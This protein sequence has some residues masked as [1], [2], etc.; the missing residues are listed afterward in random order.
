MISRYEYVKIKGVQIPKHRYVWEQANG[1]IPDGYDVHHIDGNGHNND[2]SNLQLIKHGE[3][4][5]MHVKM[6]LEG[7][8]PVD[9]T[10]E[11]II[12][13]R[14]CNRESRE[15]HKEDRKEHSRQYRLEHADEI[16][17]K[18]KIYRDTH[19]DQLKAYRTEHRDELNEYLRQYRRE[20]KEQCQSYYLARKEK[21]P[22]AIR[23]Y[24]E[25]YRQKSKV[26]NDLEQD[27]VRAIDEGYSQELVESMADGIKALREERSGRLSGKEATMTVEERISSILNA[28]SERSAKRSSYGAE[29]Y[30]AN[31]EAIAAKQK[32]Y[33]EARSL[34]AAARRALNDAYKARLSGDEISKRQSALDQAEAHLAEVV[35]QRHPTGPRK[36]KT[37]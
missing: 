14:Q 3:H 25:Q 20:H 12:R 29:Y 4:V 24:Q 2:L 5:A 7:T 17:A 10:N 1:P 19:K 37:T 34:A 22:E 16:K 6:R 32:K 15:R 30:A 33:H 27:L 9:A 31:K 35:A 8:D 36:K 18:R 21:N 13:S 26:I 28:R 11:Q 23:A